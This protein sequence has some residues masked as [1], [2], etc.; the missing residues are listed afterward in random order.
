MLCDLDGVIWLAHQPIAGSVEAV[1]RLRSSGRRVVF[2]TNNSSARI[3]EQ[4]AALAAIGIPAGGDVL[5]SAV[6]AA[7][8]VEPGER[9]L[10]CGGPGITEAVTARGAVR[11][12]ATT[13]PGVD[14]DV[15][16]GRLPPRRSTTSGCASPRRPPCAAPG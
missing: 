4:E 16:D 14:A 7:T 15:V 6:A 10:V 5:T 8:L 1:A 2:V 3:G 13:R 11:S 12:P 9:V